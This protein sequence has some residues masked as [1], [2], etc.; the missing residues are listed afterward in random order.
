MSRTVT[1]W[2]VVDTTTGEV[3]C[4]RHECDLDSATYLARPDH[5]TVVELTGELPDP[6]PHE[7]KVGDWFDSGLEPG[8]CE[9]IIAATP[10]GGWTWVR[11]DPR[12]HAVTDGF[13]SGRRMD[14][15][16]RPC[17]PPAWFTEGGAS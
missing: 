11:F 17:D 8:Y 4:L 6:P 12:G 3:A 15:G 13:W 14:K 10:G 7:W 16:E 2:A 9:R 5:L 1:A